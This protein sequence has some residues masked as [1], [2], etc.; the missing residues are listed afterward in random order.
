MSYDGDRSARRDV[1]AVL[2]G[3]AFFFAFDHTYDP[4]SSSPPLIRRF[5][6]ICSAW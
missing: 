2:V 3:L 4:A 1:V 6:L 5:T